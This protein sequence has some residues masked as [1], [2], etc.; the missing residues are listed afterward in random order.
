VRNRFFGFWI[1]A[2]LFALLL[3]SCGYKPSLNY[4]RDSIDGLVYV[5]VKFSNQN[6]K[7]TVLIKD[8]MNELVIT[9]FGAKLT[10]HK[11]LADTLIYLKLKSYSLGE[12][13][14]D[15][16]GYIK[17]YRAK[18]SIATTYSKYANGKKS[19][20]KSFTTSGFYDFSIDDD[21]SI[22]DE[23][24]F[25][26]IKESS[27]KALNEIISKIAVSNYSAKIKSK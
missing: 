26:A 19:S 14:F 23:K 9:K 8:A 17:L 6:P 22:T 13:S 2:I 15:K 21:S 24:T 7:N 11:E 1:V 16:D 3:T 27:S 25:E 12:V 4:A 5:E 10:H 20:T 18:V